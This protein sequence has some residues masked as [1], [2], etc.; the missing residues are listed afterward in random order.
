MYQWE[1]AGISPSTLQHC[2]IACV[3]KEQLTEEDSL[4]CPKFRPISILSTLWRAWSAT[5]HRS[6]PS[7]AWHNI[8][9]PCNCSGGVNGSLGPEA[10]AS[11]V[12]AKIEQ[13]GYACSLDFSNVFDSVVTVNSCKAPCCRFSPSIFIHGLAC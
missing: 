9:F 12:Q 4:P 2:R 13:Y 3:P 7:R 8:F 5:W 10:L 6:I 11:M 1:Q